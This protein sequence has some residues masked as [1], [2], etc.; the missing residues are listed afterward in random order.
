MIKHQGR[1]YAFY[2]ASAQPQW[3][4]WSNNIAVSDELV[5]WKK[6]PGNPVLPADPAHPQRSSGIV[7]HDGNRYRL[8]TMH[9][10]VWVY[11]PKTTENET[12]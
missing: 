12:K 8:Y 1:Y 7:V 2:H 5:H 10:E 6:Y 4:E 3:K 11:F 9:P